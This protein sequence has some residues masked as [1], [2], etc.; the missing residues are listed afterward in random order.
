MSCPLA[1]SLQVIIDTATPAAPERRPISAES[2]IMNPLSKVLA[3]K[4]VAQPG[5]DGDNLQIFNMELKQKLKTVQFAQSV[6]FWKWVTPRKLGLVTA[7]AVYHW[8]MD[9][10][11]AGFWGGGALGTLVGLRWVA[12]LECGGRLCERAGSL[13]SRAR[14]G[15][16]VFSYRWS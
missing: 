14:A 16:A 15:Q 5:V 1:R 11:G 7:T 9:V 3:L 4:A 12:G 6:V 13:P 8:D 2:A 10:S